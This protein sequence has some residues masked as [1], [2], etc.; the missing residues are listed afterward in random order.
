MHRPKQHGWLL[1]VASKVLKTFLL[2]LFGLLV[3]LLL[4]GILEWLPLINLLLNLLEQSL[5]K[6]IALVLC[7]VGVAVV[8]ESL[9]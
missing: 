5:P 3:S 7:L 4:A 6:A 1:R 2:S 9:R 8:L